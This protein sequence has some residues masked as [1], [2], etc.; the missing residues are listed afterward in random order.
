MIMIADAKYA[1]AST[2]IAAIWLNISPKADRPKSFVFSTFSNM[3][4]II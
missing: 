3:L 2:S 4:A 1:R